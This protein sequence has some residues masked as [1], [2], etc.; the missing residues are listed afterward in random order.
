ESA[1]TIHAVLDV[2][3]GWDWKTL[4]T[5]YPNVDEYTSQLR[6]LEAARDNDPKSAALHFLL[7]YH[8]LTCGYQDKALEEFRQTVE[9]QPKD[10]VAAALFATLSPR[11]S[12]ATQAPA[13]DAPKVVPSDSIIGAWSATGKGAAKYSLTLS[14]D[15]SFSWGFSNGKRKQEAK[16]VHTV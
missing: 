14:K 4:V 9:L 16:G 3:P 11:D 6:A 2:G 15:G 10:S 1:A 12:Q 7:G 5:L 13:G 8:Y